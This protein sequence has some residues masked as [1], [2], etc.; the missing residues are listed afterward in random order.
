MPALEEDVATEEEVSTEEEL[1]E[2]ADFFG[3]Q[4]SEDGTT[5]TTN[6]I[7]VNK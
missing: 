5:T 4:T 1:D 2:V 6:N 3:E 7:N